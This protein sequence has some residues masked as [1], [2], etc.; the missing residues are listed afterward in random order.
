MTEGLEIHGVRAVPEGM[1]WVPGGTFAMG[2]ETF[3]PEERP[4]RPV[5]VAGFFMDIRPVTNAEYAAFVLATGHVTAAERPSVPPVPSRV[6]GSYVFRQT[7]GPVPLEDRNQWWAYVPGADWRH[8]LGPAS[9]LE[10]RADHPV[11]HVT[12]ADAT[13]YASWAGKQLPTEAEW[14]FAARGGL[15]GVAYPWG[16]ELAPHGR[17]MANTWHGDF[18]WRRATPPVTSPV[19]AYDRNGLGLHDMVGNVWEW[20]ADPAAAELTARAVHPCRVPDAAGPEDERVLDGERV[21][22][23]GSHLCAPRSCHHFR[24]AARAAEPETTAA[25]HLGFRCVSR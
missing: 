15:A 22:K 14:E 19:G 8:P 24:P 5:S 1:V 3:H 21:V 13:A 18:P 4:V 25:C 6:P 23:G 16:D 12:Y 2:S 17:R 7:E 9:T 10:D 11:T 20:T